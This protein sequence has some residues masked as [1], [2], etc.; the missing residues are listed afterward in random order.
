MDITRAS[1]AAQRRLLDATVRSAVQ[2]HLADPADLLAF[3]GADE[4][5]DAEGW[6][7]LERIT[8]AAQALAA[9]K[10]HLASRRPQGDIGQGAST[11]SDTVN[12]G[13]LLRER[14]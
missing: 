9:S 3:G 4:L 13:A 12:L 6:P 10:P 14:A 7:D 8:S 2:D 11:T 5:I 1:N